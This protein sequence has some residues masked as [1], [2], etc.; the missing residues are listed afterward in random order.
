M[1]LT[2]PVPPEVSASI[3]WI[4]GQL[5]G[6]IFIIVMNALRDENGDPANNYTK[7]LI[8]EGVVSCVAVP[9]VYLLKR[10]DGRLAKDIGARYK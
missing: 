4:G 1:E 6:G 8:F 3:Y 9:L 7:A 2:H 5:L 10:K